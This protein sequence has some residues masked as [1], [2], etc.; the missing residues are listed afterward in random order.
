MANRTRNRRA[1]WGSLQYDAKTRTARIRYW[2]EGPDGYRRRSKTIRDATRKEAEQARAALMLEHG[3]D[4][5]CPTV[6]QVWERWVLPEMQQKVDG[7][8]MSNRSMTLYT[9]S[10]R[11]EI[12]TRWGATPC[13]QVRPLAVQQWISGMTYSQ[14]TYAVMLLRRVL[15]YAV[16]Y[17]FVQS[18]V[19]REK[20]LMPSKSTVKKRDD[21]TWTL[22]QLGVL[23]RDVAY[24]QTWEAAFLLSAFGGCRVGESL[25]AKSDDVRAMDVDGMTVAVIDIRRQV[26]TEGLTDRLKTSWSYR[27]VV[28][29]GRAATR[30]LEIAD[31]CDVWLAGD[32]VGNPCRRHQI[33]FGWDAAI[34]SVPKD[35]RHPYKNLRNSWQTNMRWVLKLPPWIVEPML[36]H[37]GEGTTGHHYDKPKAEMFAEMLASAYVEHPY[38][39]GWTWLDVDA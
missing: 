9:G 19:M 15:D 26:S 1:S 13:D 11:R 39:A 28:M 7:G 18:N 21:G 29:V 35:M 27:P 34:K 30:M 32:G 20:Y 37:V 22:D 16:R 23:W 25:A 10:Y 3:D 17:E 12:E 24:G 14:A 33:R 2:A 31:S 4:A 5:P 38:D 8:D 6:Q 36:G